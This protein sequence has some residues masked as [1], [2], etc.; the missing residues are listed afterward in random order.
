MLMPILL[1]LTSDLLSDTFTGSAL[2]PEWKVAK[3]Q[4]RIAEGRLEG[5]EIASDKHAAVVRR[6]VRFGDGVIRYS[7]R[8]DGAKTAHLSINGAGG[9]ICRLVLTP[10]S[11]ELRKD[12]PNAK[13]EE[14]AVRLATAAAT[15]APG[16]W[17]EVEVSFEGRAMSAKIS[18]GGAPATTLRGEHDGVAQEKTNIG[19]PV[20]GATASFDNVRVSGL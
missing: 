20:T 15:F 10:Q 16:V 9:H 12:K 13:S 6:D 1:F 18:G 3:G 2:S 14:K 19:F 4:W 5:T 7:V 11:V 8:L 17:Y